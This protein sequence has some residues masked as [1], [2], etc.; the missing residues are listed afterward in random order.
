MSDNDVTMLN[1]LIATTIDSANG[2][3]EAAKR[4]NAAGL[5]TQF[6]EFANER[7][8][9]VTILEN[10]VRRLGGTPKQ[11]GTAKA[12]AHR[13][14]LDV[15]NAVSGSDQAVL[16]EVENGET[17]IRTKYETALEDRSLSEA[18][19][20]V[21]NEAFDSVRRGHERVRG[22]NLTV[23]S[24]ASSRQ[25]S[26][27]WR[28]VGTGLGLAAAL[29]GAAYAATR[30]TGSRRRQADVRRART[31]ST[32]GRSYAG[33]TGGSSTATDLG[34]SD[35]GTAGATTM[36]VSSPTSS[37]SSAAGSSGSTSTFQQG[38]DSGRSAGASTSSGGG[39][40]LAAGG[41]TDQS[42]EGLGGF[43]A[44][45]IGSGSSGST[46]GTSFGA[47]SSG[48]DLGKK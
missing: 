27:D 40:R 2:F 6:I 39:A 30:L 23:G 21:V 45:D 15:K 24:T 37:A 11:A 17:Y 1:S 42:G 26:V 13:R 12:A 28:K 43:N 35:R 22:L 38:S 8:A 10:E 4:A 36:G 31:P 5:S 41:S 19:R 34:S 14:W 47:G 9:V 20:R 3:E 25:S 29:G 18:T 46:G 33:Q 48:G 44:S 32:G 16:Q 7:R